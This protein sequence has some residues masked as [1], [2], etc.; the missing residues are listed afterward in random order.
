M[1]VN[2]FDTRKK[3]KEALILAFLKEEG[4]S[5]AKILGELIGLKHSATFDTLKRL[6]KE[7]LLQ[8]VKTTDEVGKGSPSLW[9]LTSTGAFLATEE[10]A[11][12]YFD[13]NRASEI[14]MKHELAVQRVRVKAYNLGWS[15]WIGGRTLRKMAY[16]DRSTWLR[17]PDAF[18]V[19][20]KG[21]KVAL[22]VERTVKTYKRYPLIFSSYCQMLVDGTVQEIIYVCPNNIA[23]GLGQY[24]SNIESMCIN[25]EYLPV[26]D[27]FR[28]RFHFVTY[29]G[30]VTY[31]KDI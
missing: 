1:I 2:K 16:K 13:P 27:S 30:W 7:E 24:F 9:G 6:E 8:E 26:N 28:K 5:T 12:S 20:P 3:E 19:S 10:G 31:A 17:I 22:E 4:F 25:G 23:P 29:E 21:R 15:K 14:T 11:W 18:A